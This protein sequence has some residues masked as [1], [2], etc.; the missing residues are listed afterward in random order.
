[1]KHLRKLRILMV[2]IIA[3]V[4]LVGT[5]LAAGEIL[6]RSVAD[7]GG[8]SVDGAG[9]LHLES[10]VGQPVSGL[11][12]QNPPGGELRLCVGYLCG[13]TY[14]NMYLPIIER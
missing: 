6:P 10:A 9:G 1:M 5:A 8:E 7:A 3:L 2:V 13:D 4:I 14:L 12:V 11:L